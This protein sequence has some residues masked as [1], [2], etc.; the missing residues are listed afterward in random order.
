MVQKNNNLIVPGINDRVTF[1]LRKVNVN[2]H[3]S[4]LIIYLPLS[5]AKFY[6][7]MCLTRY[8]RERC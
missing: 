4:K 2:R 5:P 1:Y 3:I 7:L 8:E 6:F